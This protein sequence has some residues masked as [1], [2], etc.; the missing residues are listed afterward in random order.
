MFIFVLDSAPYQALVVKASGLAAG[1]GVVVA[2]DKKEACDSVDEILTD[3]KFGSAGETVVIEELLSGEEVSVSSNTL[4]VDKF[5]FNLS[6][7]GIGL[8]RWTDC[9]SHASRSRSQT[10]F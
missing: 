10:N 8:L 6:V 3:K 7:T 5:N 9:K 1:K 4:F 2:A